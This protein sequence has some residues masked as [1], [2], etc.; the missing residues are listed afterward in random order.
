MNKNIFLYIMVTVK[1]SNDAYRLIL[2]P[3]FSAK[4]NLL[5]LLCSSDRTLLSFS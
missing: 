2:P 4:E 1:L 3:V 5:A